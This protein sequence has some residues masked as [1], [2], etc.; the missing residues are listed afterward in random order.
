MEID[1]FVSIIIETLDLNAIDPLG[2]IGI[3][4]NSDNEI[5]YNLKAS[6]KTFI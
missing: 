1:F 6:W 3:F 4:F 2:G 5:S